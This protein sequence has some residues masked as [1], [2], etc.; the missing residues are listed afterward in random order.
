NWYGIRDRARRTLTSANAGHPPPLLYTGPSAADA[1][2]Q[3]LKSSGFAA[4]MVE[5]T[6]FESRTVE[7]G[8]F[9]RLLLYSDGAYEIA[10]PDG[11][12]WTIAEFVDFVS[13]LQREAPWADQILAP[14]SRLH[15]LDAPAT[16]FS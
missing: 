12:M 1:G 3:R 2:L 8:P 15:G 5:G 4:G 11:P 6:A 16:R 7:L 9:A 14:V 13:A 10:R